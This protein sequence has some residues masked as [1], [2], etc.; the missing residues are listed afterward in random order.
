MLYLLFNSYQ[1]R[2]PLFVFRYHSSKGVWM[3][4][5]VS[6]SFASVEEMRRFAKSRSLIVRRLP[7]F[8]QWKATK[9]KKKEKTH[10]DDCNETFDF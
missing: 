2:K 3:G 6:L 4:R 5:G 8:S 7:H 9:D 1:P 10:E